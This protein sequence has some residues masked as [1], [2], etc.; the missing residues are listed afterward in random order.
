[1]NIATIEGFP[2]VFP[3]FVDIERFPLVLY[4]GHI[5]EKYTCFIELRRNFCGACFIDI[6]ARRA[7]SLESFIFCSRALT[8][9]ETR[10][11]FLKVL[12]STEID[13]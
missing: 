2:D 10:P 6:A 4:S 5:P 8:W 9:V 13:F 11:A 12:P 7:T 1:L 3:G